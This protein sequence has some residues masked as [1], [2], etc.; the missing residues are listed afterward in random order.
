MEQIISKPQLKFLEAFNSATSKIFQFN[1]RSRRSEFWWIMSIVYISGILC[2]P[3]LGFFLEILMIPLIFRRLHDTGRSGWW[4]GISLILKIGFA[5]AIIYDA[6]SFCMNIPTLT[7]E[8]RPYEYDKANV[9]SYI[10][11]IYAKYALWGLVI[12]IYQ[13][14]LLII[15]CIDSDVYENDYGESPKYEIK[16]SNE[17]KQD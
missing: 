5:I 6:F 16:E 4:Y 1:G 14:V 8:V 17:E 2:T 13:I 10:F 7:N 9:I 15:F 3:V 12:F 11:T